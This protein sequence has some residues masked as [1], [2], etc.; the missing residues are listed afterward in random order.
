MKNFFFKIVRFEKKLNLEDYPIDKNQPKI[1]SSVLVE[2]F[3]LVDLGFGTKS[4][5]IGAIIKILN[6]DYKTLLEGDVIN[7]EVAYTREVKFPEEK[8]FEIYFDG[9]IYDVLKDKLN[10]NFT[11]L[12]ELDPL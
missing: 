7:I 11:F 6:H 10:F 9:L 2:K 4:S 8:E 1:I 5:G 12:I 3:N